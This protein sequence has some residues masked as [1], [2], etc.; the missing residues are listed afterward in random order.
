MPGRPGTRPPTVHMVVKDTRRIRRA[1]V[2]SLEPASA[3]WA[4]GPFPNVVFEK[5]G[6]EQGS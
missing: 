2:A 1:D 6:G 3:N 4:I 5:L